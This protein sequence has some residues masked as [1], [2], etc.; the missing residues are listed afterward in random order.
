METG[1]TLEN[2]KEACLPDGEDVSPVFDV[3][4]CPQTPLF[5]QPFPFSVTPTHI[6]THMHTYAY[7]N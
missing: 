6:Q 3:P 4:D 1:E 2:T 7:T 5:L